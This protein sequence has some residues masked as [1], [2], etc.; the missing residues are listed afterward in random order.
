M[1][2][3]SAIVFEPEDQQVLR[4]IGA[5]YHEVE[6]ITFD[7]SNHFLLTTDKPAEHAIVK[8]NLKGEFV[9]FKLT[10]LEQT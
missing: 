10:V 4:K 3:G 8:H 9:S 1:Q 5:G 7:A 6:S 2:V